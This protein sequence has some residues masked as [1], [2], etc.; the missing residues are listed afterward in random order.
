MKLRKSVR[1]FAQAM[2]R[3]LREHDATKGKRGWMPKDCAADYLMLRVEEE[4]SELRDAMEDDE[5]A[6]VV[7][8][9]AADVANMAMM[10][11]ENYAA[12]RKSRGPI[13]RPVQ[14]SPDEGGGKPLEK[15]ELP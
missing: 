5:R 1:L 13:S 15:E 2:E 10:V 7:T 11:A 9:E 14:S 12:W 4:A 6:S 8:A 3:K